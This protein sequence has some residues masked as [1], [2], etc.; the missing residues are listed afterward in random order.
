MAC[1][2]PEHPPRVPPLIRWQWLVGLVSWLFSLQACLPVPCSTTNK[3]TVTCLYRMRWYFSVSGNTIK[4]PVFIYGYTRA[5][6]LLF[7]LMWMLAVVTGQEHVYGHTCVLYFPIH[8]NHWKAF[9]KVLQKGPICSPFQNNNIEHS[10]HSAWNY[11]VMKKI[12]TLS[13]YQIF[14]LFFV[15]NREASTH[16]A[17]NQEGTLPGPKQSKA[18]FL[19]H[20][21]PWIPDTVAGKSGRISGHCSEAGDGTHL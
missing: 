17:V 6:W 4:G 5:L 11:F 8:Q 1:N 13:I 9:C 15:C 7:L 14:A 16:A 19:P 18:S 21:V 20:P 10:S 2:T 3:I 12:C